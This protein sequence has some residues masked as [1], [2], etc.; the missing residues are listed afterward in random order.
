[1][2]GSGVGGDLNVE[3]TKVIRN[4]H[5]FLYFLDFSQHF[6][7]PRKRTKNLKSLLEGSSKECY[8]GNITTV[9]IFPIFNPKARQDCDL[10]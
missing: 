1:M 8:G 4:F 9:S 6:S 10:E 2:S 7:M 5:N 3:V